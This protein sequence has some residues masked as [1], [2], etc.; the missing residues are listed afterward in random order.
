MD[1]K[2]ENLDEQRLRKIIRQSIQLVESRKKE[3]YLSEE[4]RLRAV[5]RTLLNEDPVGATRDAPYNSTGLNT[6]N[7]LFDNILT[8]LEDGYKGLAS[9][10]EQRDS[11]A[12]HILVNIVNT[13]APLRSLDDQEKNLTEEIDIEIKDDPA[14]M[15]DVRMSDEEKEL[16]DFTI[17]GKDLTGRDKALVAFKNIQTQ[18]V[19]AYKTLHNKE[20]IDMFYNGLLTN[21]ELYFKKF[22]D[23]MQP[24]VEKPDTG[25]DNEVPASPEE[26]EEDMDLEDIANL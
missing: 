22:E 14:Q 20:D 1:N 3:K 24:D 4:N 25:A 19:D 17:P 15:D 9:E 12:A 6:L 8:Q 26:P 5:I 18:I 7:N 11:F 10:K 23:E 13:L 16:Q 2:I 21:V